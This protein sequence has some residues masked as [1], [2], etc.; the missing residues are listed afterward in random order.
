MGHLTRSP[1]PRAAA[2]TARCLIRCECMTHVLQKRLL[3]HQAS[4]ASCAPVQAAFAL[5]YA[6]AYALAPRA[7]HAFVC[8][9]SGLTGETI[10][11]ALRDLDA[12]AVPAWERLAAPASA[13]AYWGLPVRPCSS[14]KLF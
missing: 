5:P 13:A 1:S 10:S 9:L 2:R 11:D 4:I 6:A 3:P 7:C 14:S 8:H 12:G